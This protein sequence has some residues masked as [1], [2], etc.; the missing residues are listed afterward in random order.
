[1]TRRARTILSQH[2]VDGVHD[3]LLAGHGTANA[4]GIEHISEGVS[5]NG[6]EFVVDR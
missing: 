3:T 2:E 4:D 6:I 5:P 1:M